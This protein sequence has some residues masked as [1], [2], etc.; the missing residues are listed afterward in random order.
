MLMLT[1][2]GVSAGLGRGNAYVLH[3]K[4]YT[5]P[6]DLVCDITAESRRFEAAFHKILE[7]TRQMVANV[8]NGDS[9]CKTDIMDAYLAL[10]EDPATTDG[11]RGLITASHNAVFAVHRGFGDIIRLFDQMQNDYMRERVYDILDMQNRLIR[12]LLG[13]QRYVP[14]PVPPG[15]IIVAEDLSTSDTATMN[16]QNACGIIT[17]LGGQNSHTSIVARSMEIPAVVGAESILDLIKDGDQIL[18]NGTE[19]T[20]LVSPTDDLVKKF[21]IE[22]E[23]YRAQQDALNYFAS[24]T[25]FTKDGVAVQVCANISSPQEIPRLLSCGAEGVGLFRTEFLFMGEHL[26]GEEE[27]YKAYRKIAEAL[28]GKPVVIRTMDVG[29]EKKA[30][31]FSW[32]EEPNPALGYRAIRVHLDRKDLFKTQLRAMLRASA[33]GQIAIKFPMITSLEEL[34]AAKDLLKDAQDELHQEHIPFDEALRVGVMIEVPAAVMIAEE[35]AKEC[36][37]FSIGT[38][39]LIQYT[40]AADRSNRRVSYLYTQYHPAVLRQ[41]AMTIHAAHNRGIAC[42]LCGEAASDPLL[43]PLLLGMG[44]DVFSTHIGQVLKIRSQLAEMTAAQAQALTHE[45]LSL[46]TATEVKT[47]LEQFYADKR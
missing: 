32:D 43:I 36:D 37:F 23:L 14:P 22:Q 7:E 9:Y 35:L 27:Q 24:K 2:I 38:N 17:I 40:L 44:L 33:H 20:I 28:D 13:F 46:S 19:G 4:P 47:R 1:A 39:D 42:G 26:P 21:H 10:L 31:P 5:I 12:E 30:S 16:L 34:R 45:V 18:L 29:G 8:R 3:K 41:I 6:D 15:S 11:V 25:S